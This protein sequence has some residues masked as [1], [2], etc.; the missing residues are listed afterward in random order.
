LSQQD[1]CLSKFICKGETQ[2]CPNA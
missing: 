2:Y 1:E